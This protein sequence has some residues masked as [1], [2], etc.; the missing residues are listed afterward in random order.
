MKLALVGSVFMVMIAFGLPAKASDKAKAAPAAAHKMHEKHDHKHGEGCGHKAV[1]HDGHKDF[2][3]DGHMHKADGDH[4]DE[5][6][7]KKS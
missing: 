5:C 7:S 4:Y 3:H 6:A 2:E 1:D